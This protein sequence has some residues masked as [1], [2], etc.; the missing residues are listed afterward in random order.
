[1]DADRT[2]GGATGAAGQ[3]AQCKFS[4]NGGR[5]GP[6]LSA[7]QA[8]ARSTNFWPPPL[9]FASTGRQE[10]GDKTDR[11]RGAPSPSHQP[12]A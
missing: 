12:P 6:P 3:G 5:A 10:L 11:E 7:G 9:A 1:M 4:M 8:L 2:R